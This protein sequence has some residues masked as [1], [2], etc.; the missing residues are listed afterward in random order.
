[1]DR[2][3]KPLRRILV[4]AGITIAALVLL[5]AAIYAGV[6]LMLAPMMQ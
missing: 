6:F 2:N 5:A 3:A 4:I 1:M